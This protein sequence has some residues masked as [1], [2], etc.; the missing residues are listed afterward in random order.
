MA[1]LF[2]ASAVILTAVDSGLTGVALLSGETP[3]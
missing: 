2:G 1:V 3:L